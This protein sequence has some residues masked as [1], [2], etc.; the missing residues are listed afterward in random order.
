M[1]GRGYSLYGNFESKLSIGLNSAVGST[2]G[3]ASI[4]FHPTNYLEDVVKYTY[5]DGQITGLMYGDRKISAVDKT[6]YLD[7]KNYLYVELSF[8]IQKGVTEYCKYIDGIEGRIVQLPKDVDI[9]N[10]KK[11]KKS[12][13]LKEYGLIS[14]RWTKEIYYED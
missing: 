3:T 4:S 2:E 12:K 11:I 10:I 6:Y 9:S 1:K 13:K 14:G 5:P 7:T 8:G